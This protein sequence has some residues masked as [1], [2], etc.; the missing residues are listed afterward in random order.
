MTTKRTTK[1]KTAISKKGNEEMRTDSKNEIVP[2]QQNL[3]ATALC[4]IDAFLEATAAES[5]KYL[6]FAK[7]EWLA[8]VDEEDVEAG[9]EM[10]VNITG[11]TC[12][13]VKWEDKVPVDESMTPII[14]GM[15]TPR[16]SLG[17]LD[18]DLWE[19]DD[20][21]APKDPWT[22]TTKVPLKNPATDEE[23]IYSTN[24]KGGIG[25]VGRMVS[26]VRRGHRQGNTGLPV[27]RLD[28]DSYKHKNKEYGKVFVP[29]F[30][31]VGFKLEAELAGGEADLDAELDDEIP[32][33]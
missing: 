31:L 7:G 22:R 21:G 2:A 25:A 3:P 12:G 15:F 19:T 16:E 8:G 27:I 32:G 6:K 24:S 30:T 5:A 26:A 33:F 17:D 20:D 11:I 14:E 28:V 1:T 10:V 18:R 4:N 13:H 23:F 9:T 29:Q